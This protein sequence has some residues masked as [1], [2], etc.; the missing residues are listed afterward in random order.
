MYK[1]IPKYRS[2]LGVPEFIVFLKEIM[3]GNIIEGNGNVHFEKKIA[4]YS[5]CKYGISCSTGR[6][7]LY[8]IL[9]ALSLKPHDEV[10]VPAYTCLVVTNA[11]IGNNCK[12]IFADID[13]KTFNLDPY[14]LEDLVSENT[15]VIIPHHLFGLPAN[16]KP[17]IEIAE[18]YGITIVE[19]AAQAL[20]AEYYGKKV[21]S[22][23]D[24]AI[25]SFGDL[26]PMS[27]G[28]G[29]VIVTNDLK[30]AK[31]VQKITK[32]YPYPTRLH[33]ITDIIRLFG[34]EFSNHPLLYNTTTSIVSR[35]LKVFDFKVY[36]TIRKC[37]EEGC[38]IPEEY[39]TRF[40]NIR[41][42]I[43]SMLLE[44]LE[45]SIEKRIQNA[46]YYTKNLKDIE[47]LQLPYVPS[48]SKH[49]FL[50]YMILLNQNKKFDRN[51]LLKCLRKKG[52]GATTWSEYV[53]HPSQS[54]RLRLGYTEGMCPVAEYCSKNA[55]ALPVYPHLTKEDLEYIITSLRDCIKI[56]SK[57]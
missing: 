52:V 10:I 4:E 47:I 49:T 33:E 25:H 32:S 35:I 48:H 6:I 27:L 5:G 22:F 54:V 7:A 2:I 51:A 34:R 19:D 37:E 42:I 56:L 16:I 8:T 39:F 45:K 15:K 36:S 28:K 14:I 55:F 53:V 24:A 17:I 12:I 40:S 30:L 29:G 38:D 50:E 13:K 11:I 1:R 23:G 41:S 3:T 9:K 46:Q 20:G 21:G 57:K 18:Q 26:K 43:G 31:N 44:K